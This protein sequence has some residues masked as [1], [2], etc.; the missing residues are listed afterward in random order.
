MSVNLDSW[1]III[2]AAL[3]LIICGFITHD[4]FFNSDSIVH[5]IT[6]FATFFSILGSLCSMFAF[7]LAYKIYNDWKRDAINRELHQ[8]AVIL[9]SNSVYIRTDYKDLHEYYLKETN[10]FNSNFILNY[11]KLSELLPELKSFIVLAEALLI[12]ENLNFFNLKKLIESIDIQ[13]YQNQYSKN[14]LD[15]L[16]SD[17]SL[18][19]HSTPETYM[20]NYK[21]NRFSSNNDILDRL[22]CFEKDPKLDTNVFDSALDE[23]LVFIKQ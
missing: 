11:N 12:K 10:K 21:Q 7:Y 9:Y 8:K 14:I 20:S 22:S 5:S 17:S 6:T 19:F 16:G 23:L 2:L 18:F 1:K 13:L 4:V 15:M 3:S